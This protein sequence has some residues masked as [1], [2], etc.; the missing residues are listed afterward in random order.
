MTHLFCRVRRSYDELKDVF[1]RLS[2]KCSQ[3]AVYEHPKE[4]NVHVHFLIMDIIVSTDTLKN[5]IRSKV[6]L[7][8]KTDWSFKTTYKADNEQIPITHESKLGAIL[9]MSNGK[10]DSSY[11]IGFAAEVLNEC[12]AKWVNKP[13]QQTKAVEAKQNKQTK[14][15]ML[16]KMLEKITI[17]TIK[18]MNE[19]DIYK[20]IRGV[21]IENDQVLGIYKV[22]EF[23]DAV[24]MRV[25]RKGFFEEYQNIIQKRKPM[26]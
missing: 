19:Y 3:L 18:T 14:K 7:V 4:G 21:L 1:P 24:M 12:K 13:I 17:D 6:G 15:D 16:N 9:Y 11:Q 26:L 2:G 23:R 5:Y 8:V 10:Y 20:N 22:L 25:D